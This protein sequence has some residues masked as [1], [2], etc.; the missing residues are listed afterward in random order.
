[1]PKQNVRRTI[2]REWMSRPAAMRQSMQQAVQFARKA[3]EQH[4]LP[5][6]RLAPFVTI[7]RWLGPRTGR[8]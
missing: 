4:T 5:R 7:M 8:V 2:I 1:M 6:R 3:V